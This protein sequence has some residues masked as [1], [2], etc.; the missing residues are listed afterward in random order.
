MPDTCNFCSSKGCFFLRKSHGIGNP[1]NF[2]AFWNIT[3]F[4]SLFQR[5]FF[6]SLEVGSFLFFFNPNSAPRFE[7]KSILV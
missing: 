1:A 4:F 3:L 7:V 2:L 6:Q 5:F